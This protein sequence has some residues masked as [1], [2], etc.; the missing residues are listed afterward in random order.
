MDR[1]LTENH[2]KALIARL[3]VIYDEKVLV[4][5]TALKP[6]DDV[7]D[8]PYITVDDGDYI[9]LAEEGGGYDLYYRQT[10]PGSMDEPPSEDY[11][12]VKSEFAFISVNHVARAILRRAIDAH[13]DEVD[14]SEI[15]DESETP[16]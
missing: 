7:W 5:N 14:M 10:Y 11:L 1:I 2:V 4:G 16:F 8:T 9:I 3:A 13:I 12:P 6:A 15:P